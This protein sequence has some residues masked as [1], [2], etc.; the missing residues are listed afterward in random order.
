VAVV[1]MY[2]LGMWGVLLMCFAGVAES[3]VQRLDMVVGHD[4]EGVFIVQVAIPAV[5]MMQLTGQQQLK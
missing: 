5:R 1:D 2:R 3:Q 4:S